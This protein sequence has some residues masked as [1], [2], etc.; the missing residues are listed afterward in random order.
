V[1][2]RSRGER[3]GARELKATILLAIGALRLKRAP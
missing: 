3:R 2:G 1:A